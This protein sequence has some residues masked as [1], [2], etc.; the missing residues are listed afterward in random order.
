MFH[1]MGKETPIAI[2]KNKSSCVKPLVTGTS[3]PQKHLL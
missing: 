2:T 3:A 1:L